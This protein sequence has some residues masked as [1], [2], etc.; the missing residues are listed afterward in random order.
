MRPC[1]SALQRAEEAARRPQQPGRDH[2]PA[3]RRR[4]QAAVPHDRL[5]PQQGRRAGQGAIRSNTIPNRSAR[6]ALLHYADGEK[7]YIL[8]PDGLK[9]GDEVMSGPDAPPSVGN[10]LP[11]RNI[12]LGMTIHNIELQPGRGGGCAARPASSATLGG[13]R[14]RLGAD[15]SA[16]RRNSP[17]A[18]RPAGPRSARSATPTT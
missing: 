15:H 3:S 9:A 5:P 17:R 6:I 10:C 18:R 4:P 13:P 8:A 7:R 2:R 11:L 12:P 14:G 1:R 16:Q